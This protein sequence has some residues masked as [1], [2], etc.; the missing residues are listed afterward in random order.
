MDKIEQM[1]HKEAVKMATLTN[2]ILTVIEME[3]DYWIQLK[4]IMRK[5]VVTS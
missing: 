1:S 4:R 2:M 3:T 5:K